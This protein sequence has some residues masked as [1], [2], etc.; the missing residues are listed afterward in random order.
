[1]SRNV[2]LQDVMADE[3]LSW[4]DDFPLVD[5]NDSTCNRGLGILGF[6]FFQ[7]SPTYS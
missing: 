2:L 4:K 5:T 6:H 1:M 7:S 3:P